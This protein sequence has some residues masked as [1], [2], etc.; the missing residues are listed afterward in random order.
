MKGFAI[1][2]DAV[3]A[4]TFFLLAMLVVSTQTYQPTSPN[5]IYLKE[6]TLDTLT[7][8]EK[9]GDLDQALG[10]NTV[11]AYQLVESTPELACIQVSITNPAQSVVATLVKGGCNDTI[12]LDI[13]AA[14]MPL[15]YDGSEYVATSESWFRAGS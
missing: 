1:T 15:L 14:S 13:Q 8:L 11:P 4:L 7:V 2:L 10:G 3:I 6:L 5:E 9:T 12:G